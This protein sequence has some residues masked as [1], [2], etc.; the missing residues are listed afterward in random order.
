MG[1]AVTDEHQ[2]AAGA[3]VI[4]LFISPSACFIR[5]VGRVNWSAQISS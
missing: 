2:I 5:V 3:L 4:R 1:S